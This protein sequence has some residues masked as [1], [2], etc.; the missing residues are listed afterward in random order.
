[1]EQFFHLNESCIEVK[2]IKPKLS[3]RAGRTSEA[4]LTPNV[5]HAT[6]AHIHYPKNRK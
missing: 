6:M 5:L 2:R 4:A 3:I 1:M